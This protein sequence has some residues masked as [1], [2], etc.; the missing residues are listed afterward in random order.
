MKELNHDS[1]DSKSI[2]SRRLLLKGS[3]LLC[4]VHLSG[5]SSLLAFG[6]DPVAPAQQAAGDGK[7]G[8]VEPFV[9]QG[10]RLFVI[11]PEDNGNFVR[12][13]LPKIK[14]SPLALRSVR[15]G[16]IEGNQAHQHELEQP[17]RVQ[18]LIDV[19]RRMRPA[20]EAPAQ[21]AP[22]QEAPASA[23]RWKPIEMKP[24]AQIAPAQEAP[25]QAEIRGR[26]ARMAPPTLIW[27]VWANQEAANQ[28]AQIQGVKSVTEKEPDHVLESGMAANAGGVLSVMLLPSKGN[29]QPSQNAFA[30]VQQVVH[31]LRE[32]TTGNDTVTFSVVE[33]K[34]LEEFAPMGKI[35]K[36]QIK[37][38]FTTPNLDE[39]VLEMIKSHPQVMQMKWGGEFA[40]MSCPGCGL[41]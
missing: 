2:L 30:T 29:R 19:Q 27:L 34:G 33:A 5:A 9:D 1:P 13:V 12:E 36:E 14:P 15:P 7:E 41:G 32:A 4:G 3:A 6:Q 21:I 18:R 24:P 23:D 16:G 38:E 8:K 28:I 26:E 25:A 37:I 20:Q 39:Q 10:Y 35:V 22:A 40:E 31:E 11:E 17:P